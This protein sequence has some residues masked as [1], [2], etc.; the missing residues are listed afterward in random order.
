MINLANTGTT[1][2]I[3]ELYC[4]TTGTTPIYLFEVVKVGSDNI[5]SFIAADT[6][7]VPCRYQSFNIIVSATEN[8][9]NGQ[10]N[11]STGE[12]DYTV[13]QVNSVSL[14]AN[15]LIKLQTGILIVAEGIID[16]VYV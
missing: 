8:L 7:N 1:Q 15:K 2:V 13:Y 5:K 4:S 12:Y 3:L 16:S 11:L 6:S 9:L 10:I 14:S